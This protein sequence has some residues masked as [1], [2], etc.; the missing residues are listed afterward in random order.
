MPNSL[1]WMGSS[2]RRRTI[3][4][5]KAAEKEVVLA[6]VE[7]AVVVIVAMKGEVEAHFRHFWATSRIFSSK[8]IA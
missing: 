4:K 1:A 6:I 8:R 5:L 3:F 7:V 2:I